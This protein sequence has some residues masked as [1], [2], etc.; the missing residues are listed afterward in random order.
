ML[1]PQQSAAILEVV[2]LCRSEADRAWAHY[3][4]TAKTNRDGYLSHEA[5]VMLDWSVKLNAAARTLDTLLE[6][7]RQAG[8]ADQLGPVKTAP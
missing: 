5:Q 3:N 2:N 1:T 8:A 6:R 7:D 4:A